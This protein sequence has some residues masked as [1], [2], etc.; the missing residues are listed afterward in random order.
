[1]INYSFVNIRSIKLN[2]LLSQA[3]VF[4]T[5]SERAY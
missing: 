3:D 2:V 1:M 5:L 4:V